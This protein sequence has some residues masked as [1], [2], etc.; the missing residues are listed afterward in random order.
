MGV[1]RKS[2]ALGSAAQPSRPS[3]LRQTRARLT[4]GA[5]HSPA[6][7]VASRL[8]Y[9]EKRTSTGFVLHLAVE[10]FPSRP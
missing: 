2:L 6:Y 8:G 1:I 3:V 5:S 4:A 7:F 10:P 9:G